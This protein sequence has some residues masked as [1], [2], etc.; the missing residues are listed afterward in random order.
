MDL[1]GG[2]HPFGG[3]PRVK[4]NPYWKGGVIVPMLEF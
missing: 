1:D 2:L 3:A 4:G